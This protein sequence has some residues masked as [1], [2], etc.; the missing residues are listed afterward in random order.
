VQLWSGQLGVGTHCRLPKISIY[1]FGLSDAVA[2]GFSLF[3]VPAP[4]ADSTCSS[5]QCSNS[6][7]M[8]GNFTLVMTG[9]GCSV[10]SC[11]YGGYANGTIITT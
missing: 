10:T 7:M 2:L 9:A 11:D 5:M 3:C 1:Q 4:L 6:S 8:L